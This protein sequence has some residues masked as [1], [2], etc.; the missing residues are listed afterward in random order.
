MKNISVVIPAYNEEGNVGELVSRID[1]TFNE[2]KDYDYKILKQ[3]VQVSGQDC[4]LLEARPKTEK[5]ARETGYLKT[6]IW[7]DKSRMIVLQTKA[8][9]KAGKRLKYLKFEDIKK[10]DGIWVIHKL[11][12]QTRKGKS[13]ESTTVMIYSELKLNDKTVSEKDFSQREMEK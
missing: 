9:V 11:S 1:A 8:W 5:A 4:W 10:V 6:N 12:A 3:S 7:V 13:I 2:L